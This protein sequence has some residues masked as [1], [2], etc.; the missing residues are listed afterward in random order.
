M[1]RRYVPPPSSVHR[2]SVLSRPASLVAVQP[3][4]RAVSFA[5]DLRNKILHD[6][7]QQPGRGHSSQKDRP[8]SEHPLPAL[9]SQPQAPSSI[10]EPVIH[11]Q[12]KHGGDK[13]DAVPLK[14]SFHLPATE[15]GERD[16]D[17]VSI[18]ANTGVKAPTWPTGRM[19]E[20]D[21]VDTLRREHRQLREDI[22]GLKD[23][24]RAFKEA[25]LVGVRP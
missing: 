10:T 6:K 24:L 4:S 5:E 11:E 18:K 22:A 8:N 12:K 3:P 15:K 7:V 23:E 17:P 21:S 25:L 2:E 20:L 1:E 19:G 9:R 13:S 16:K 14:G